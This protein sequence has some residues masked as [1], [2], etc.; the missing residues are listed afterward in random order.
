MNFVKTSVIHNTCESVKYDDQTSGQ[1]NQKGK[2]GI[3]YIRPENSKPS[4]LK[5]DLIKRKRKLVLSP[6]FLTSIGGIRRRLNSFYAS[7]LSLLFRWNLHGFSDLVK[8]PVWENLNKGSEVLSAESAE[9]NIHL[10][11]VFSLDLQSEMASA[12]ITNALQV[13]FNSVLGISDNDEMVNRFKAL[14]STGLR[15]FLGCPKYV[16][17]PEDSFAGIFNLPTE[18]LTDLSEVPNNLMLQER[19]LFSKSSVPVQFSCKKRLMKYEFRLLNDILSKSITVKAGSFDAVTQERTTKRAKGF[20]AQ[21]CVLLKSDP[22][23][24]L[25]EE[26]IFPPLKILSAKTVNTYV[27]TNKTIDAH[28][29]TDEPEVA[30]VA[31]VKKKYVSKKRSV[32]TAIKDTAEIIDTISVHSSDSSSSSTSS[33]HNQMDS[34]VKC[35]MN[36]ETSANH[37]DFL[38]DT[39]VYGETP[40]TQIS[41]PAVDPTDVTESFSQL[42]ASITRL[43]VN[44]LNTSSKIGDLQNHILFK[45]ANLEKAF[46]EALS[47]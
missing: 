7:D 3:G 33:S 25:G 21:I 28:G 32:P 38:V 47:N 46:K 30:K 45:I 35:P 40:I 36:E 23:V 24:T 31:I 22:T 10:S 11:G 37:I 9:Y 44:Q 4:W 27:A 12:F 42:R 19:T 16:A 43:S 8:P 6:L 39:A 20:V 15:G 18:G 14:E 1:L 34:R 41:L 17:I 26:K 29:E 2:A 13:N 5:K